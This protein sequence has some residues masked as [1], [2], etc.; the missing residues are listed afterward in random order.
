MVNITITLD[1]NKQIIIEVTGN[2]AIEACAAFKKVVSELEP[3]S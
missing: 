2:S 3:D 1:V